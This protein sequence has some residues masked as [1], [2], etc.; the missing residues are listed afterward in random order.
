MGGQIHV[1]HCNGYTNYSLVKGKL[2]PLTAL[3]MA[4]TSQNGISFSSWGKID[5]ENL[6]TSKKQLGSLPLGPNIFS[7]TYF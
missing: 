7:F 4:K 2:G 6:L 3:D 5:F 1:T